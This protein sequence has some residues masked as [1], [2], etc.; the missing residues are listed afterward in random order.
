MSTIALGGGCHWCTEAIFHALKGVDLVQQGWVSSFEEAESF[1]EA[2][3]VHF[4]PELIPLEI[5]IEIHL[6]THNA[7]SMHS[8]RKKYRSAIY[9]YSEQQAEEVNTILKQKATLFSKKIITKVY[10]FQAF[11]SNEER[12]LNYYEKNKSKPFCKTYI[13]PKLQLL[14]QSHKRYL[15][16]DSKA[17]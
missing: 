13:T 8:M 10:P 11:K 2:V 3:V 9:T 6:L 12:Y 5:L 7:T 4:D 16:E 14:L 15:Q 17:I 1:S